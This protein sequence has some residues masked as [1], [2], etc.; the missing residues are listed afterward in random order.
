[1][2]LFDSI[3]YPISC[4]PTEEELSAIPEELYRKWLQ[5]CGYGWV[6]SPYAMTALYRFDPFV[7]DVQ[8]LRKMILEYEDDNV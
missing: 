1:M 2:S 5:M 7:E 4:P 6:S 8:L 3:K